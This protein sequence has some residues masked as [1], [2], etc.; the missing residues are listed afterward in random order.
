MAQD[1]DQHVRLT[2]H[3]LGLPVCSGFN[4]ATNQ[5]SLVPFGLS[6]QMPIAG[7]RRVNST[8]DNVFGTCCRSPLACVQAQQFSGVVA[9]D[10]R[11]NLGRQ[12][13]FGV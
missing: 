3:R 11:F 7:Q 8:V 13:E 4:H 9:V 2:S 10:F 12:F 6:H 1:H 5:H